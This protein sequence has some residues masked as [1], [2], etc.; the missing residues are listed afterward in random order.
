MMEEFLISQEVALSGNGIN[1]DSGSVSR[2]EIPVYFFNIKGKTESNHDTLTLACQGGHTKLV[3][4]LVSRGVNL[5]HR[6]KKRIYA[7]DTLNHR[8]IQRNLRDSS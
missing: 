5:E 7:F 3:Q 2:E 4:L 8:L 6:D 1:V